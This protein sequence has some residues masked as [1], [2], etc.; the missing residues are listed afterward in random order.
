MS[1]TPSD[2]YVFPFYDRPASLVETQIAHMTERADMAVAQSNAAIQQLANFEPPAEGTPPD[3]RPD[4]IALSDTPSV[5]VPD[6]QLFGQ[7]DQ[8]NEPPFEDFQSLI[9]GLDIGTA[10]T[11]DR[12]AKQL[13]RI[14]ETRTR[15]PA[16]D[17]DVDR[18]LM[19]SVLTAYPDRVGKRRAPK[20]AEIVFAGG[21][22]GSLAASSSVIEPD[23]MVAVDVSETGGRGQASRVQIR[24]AS[25]VDATWLLDL[26]MDRIAEVDELVARKRA[27]AEKMA[28]E[29]RDHVQHGKVLDRLEEQL[30]AAYDRSRLPEAPTTAA[31]L[32]QFVVDLRLKAAGALE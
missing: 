30:K 31:A 19:I 9:D 20:S 8:I 13:E 10:H 7:I 16:S 27:G 32:D 15:P 22:S 25:A 5:T 24:R 6:P 21:G 17:D 28:L 12:A 29:D 11:V 14:V 26:Y 2:F 1:T 4:S 3:I 18:E 23:L